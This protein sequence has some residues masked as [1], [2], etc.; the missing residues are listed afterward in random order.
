[1]RNIPDL[2]KMNVTYNYIM[3]NKNTA[4][5]INSGVLN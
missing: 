2:E 5:A 1:M 4:T 3:I